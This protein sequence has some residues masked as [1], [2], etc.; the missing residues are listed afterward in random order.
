M[1]EFK[2]NQRWIGIYKSIK[3]EI[4]KWNND[5]TPETEQFNTGYKW[6]AYIFVKPRRIKVSNGRIDYYKMY[7]DVEMH[8]G[9]TYWHRV[10]NSTKDIVDCIGCDYC[11]S[12]DY[13]DSYDHKLIDRDEEEILFDIKKTIDCLPEDLFFTTPNKDK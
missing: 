4:V 2:G 5:Y 9:I 1:K 6:C 7:S 8:G 11:H 10:Q 12:W 3:F 13:K